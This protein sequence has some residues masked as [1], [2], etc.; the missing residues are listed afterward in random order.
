MHTYRSRAE[1]TKYRKYLKERR[2]SGKA[3]DCIFCEMS[4]EDVAVV[5]S[6]TYFTLVKARFNYSVWDGEDVQ[7][8]LM[9]VPKQHTDTLSDLPDDAVLEFHKLMTSYEDK[10]YHVY[11]RAKGSS[12]KSIVHQHTHLIKCGGKRRKAVLFSEKPYIRI[13]F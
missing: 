1:N 2:V 13:T 7:D 4:P 12:V 3:Q 10:G 8:H 5:R 6:T 9:I 11:A